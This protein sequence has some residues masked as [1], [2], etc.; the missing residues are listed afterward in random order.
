MAGMLQDPWLS[1]RMADRAAIQRA[2]SVLY[3]AVRAAV[4][5]YLAEVLAEVLHTTT[6]SAHRFAAQPPD[7]NGFPD[8]SF[9]TRLVEG[10]IRPAT[11]RVFDRAYLQYNALRDRMAGRSEDHA[12]GLAH[13]LAAFPRHVYE[14]IRTGLAEGLTRGESPAEL[15]AR[16]AALATLEEWDGRIM[17]MTRTETMAALNAGAFQGALAQ[18]EE[19]GVKWQKRWQATHDQRVRHTHKDA[20]GQVRDLTR[21]FRVGESRLQF[22]GDPTGPPDEVI[23]CR[24]SA[25]YGPA[26]DSSLTAAPLTRRTP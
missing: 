21:A 4:R 13:R 25:R 3:T 5:E 18:Q 22:P 14:R 9:W 20:D 24:C 17:T 19:T 7:L 1:A 11:R 23:N 12:E 26:G 8:D 10:R 6:A 2:E 15:R 16:V